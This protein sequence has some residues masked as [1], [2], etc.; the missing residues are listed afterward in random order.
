MALKGK[1]QKYAEGRANGLAPKDAARMAGY[2]EGG[3][4][5]V[6]VSRMEA[7]ADVK[8]EV[9]RLRKQSGAAEP[10]EG[11][12]QW[13]LKD[14][15]DSPLELML[16][17]MNN[18]LAP[19]SARYGAAKDALPYCHARKE[20]GKKDEAAKES[21]KAAAGKFGSSPAPSHLRRVA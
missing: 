21:K 11:R 14:H 6:A 3:S 7:R 10:D 17:V 9:D 15:Y 1:M 18:P 4:L 12:E 8:A 16:D 2:A 19:V 20:G 5:K 13:G